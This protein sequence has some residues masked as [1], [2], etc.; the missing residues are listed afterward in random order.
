MPNLFIT[1]GVRHFPFQSS[2]MTHVKTRGFTLI[3]LMIVIAI[4]GILAAIAVPAYADYVYRSQLG[5][6]HRE[7]TS[8]TSAIEVALSYNQI[9]SLQSNAEE[10]VG[11]ID[12]SLSTVTFGSFTD[13]ANSTVTAV[14]DG[15]T[16]A[17][18][19]GTTIQI[20]RNGNGVWRCII[21][22]VGTAFKDSLKPNAC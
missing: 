20:I 6:V 8:Y 14:M 9:A 18:I 21:T 22:G 2:S 5:R 3:E 1:K 16:G 4:I 19:R 11:F 12:S 17:G 10:T 13:D 7:I 15:K